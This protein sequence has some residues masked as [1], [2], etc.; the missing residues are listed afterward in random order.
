MDYGVYT[1]GD[2]LPNVRYFMKQNIS[3]K[4]Y[5]DIMDAQNKY[6]KL[7]TTQF[8][9]VKT[10]HPLKEKDVGTALLHKNYQL[11]ADYSDKKTETVHYWLFESKK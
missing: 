5:T 8:V 3:S 4:V 11:V 7:K 6:I 9:I 2:L 1:A 10:K